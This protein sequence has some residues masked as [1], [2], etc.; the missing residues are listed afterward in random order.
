MSDRIKKI[1]IKQS[2][3]TFSDYIPIGA[4]AKNIDT[5]RGE[6]V[7]SV[8]DKTARYYD[9]V[10]E[11]KLD[12]NIQVGDTCVT[13]GYYEVN[14]YGGSF[15]KITDLED[16]NLYQIKLNNNLYATILNF[17]NIEQIGTKANQNITDI[18]IG[19]KNQY[20][21]IE[22]NNNYIMDN[23]INIK[24][25]LEINGNNHII[26]VNNNSTLFINSFNLIL[27]NIIFTS[28]NEYCP[29]HIIYNS[30]N[31][32]IN[33][34]IFENFKRLNNTS[35]ISV[36]QNMANAEIY[37]CIF[38]NLIC[39][40]N[41]VVADETGVLRAIQSIS[42]TNNSN[43]IIIDNCE[44]YNINN[45][46]DD[47]EIIED[48]ADAIVLQGLSTFTKANIFNCYFKNAGKR[49]IKIQGNNINI[50]NIIIDNSTYS[51]ELESIM[52]LQGE[53]INVKNVAGNANKSKYGFFILNS[54]NI[55]IS[56]I[57]ITGIMDYSTNGTPASI[58]ISNSSNIN[59]SNGTMKGFSKGLN[60]IGSISK[61]INI[62]NI[63]FLDCNNHFLSIIPRTQSESNPVEQVIIQNIVIDSCYFN[64]KGNSVNRTLS[65]TSTNTEND[66]DNNIKIL[67]STFELEKLTYRSGTILFNSNIIIENC[68]F[69]LTNNEAIQSPSLI[70]ANKRFTA[71]NCEFNF[72]Q[73]EEYN[74][75]FRLSS[76]ADAYI[77]NSKFTHRIRIE[78]ESKLISNYNTIPTFYGESESNLIRNN[79][80]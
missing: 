24:N 2:D 31:L 10:A 28:N 46:N 5:T 43:S 12:D 9:S 57:S 40:G 65:I 61:N 20:K 36:I 59:V 68:V 67:N 6:S 60:I 62:K 14:D 39:K 55:N 71:L 77:E 66:I 16:D 45:I 74:P 3:G 73:N 38:R 29:S 37:N 41:P 1:K 34:C 23:T 17:K 7:Q 19:I 33:N 50:D 58:T 32:Y 72:L 30:G 26:T 53:N 51:L 56:N 80:L 21:Y 47:G 64:C 63:N 44:F 18:I 11:M 78:D 69:N 79:R 35:Q 70:V 76:N 27:K 48:D 49:V 4:D 52:Q 54:K 15:Y 22:I 42:E 8:V 25:N 13:L 75:D